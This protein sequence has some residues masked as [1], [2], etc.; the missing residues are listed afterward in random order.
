VCPLTI[1][2]GATPYVCSQTCLQKRIYSFE[3]VHY[4]NNII[5][6]FRHLAIEYYMYKSKL[7]YCVVPE[8]VHIPPTEGIGN[9]QGWGGVLKGQKHFGKCMKLSWNFQIGYVECC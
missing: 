3:D 4:N 8:N 9:S 7:H 6:V 2:P 1:R 5:I